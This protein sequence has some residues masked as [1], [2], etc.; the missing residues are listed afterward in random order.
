MQ[1]LGVLN[2]HI[3]ATKKHSQSLILQ[4]EL[5]GVSL[6]TLSYYRYVPGRNHA[7]SLYC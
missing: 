6:V 4:V 2:M 7:Q 5:Q 3:G 1:A